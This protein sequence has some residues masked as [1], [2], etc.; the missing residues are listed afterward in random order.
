MFLRLGAWL[1]FTGAVGFG[2]ALRPERLRPDFPLKEVFVVLGGLGLLLLL[3]ETAL[4][5]F[6]RAARPPAPDDA[7]R[8]DG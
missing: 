1:V 7:D 5:H 3:A 6:G 2:L 4:R 8:D